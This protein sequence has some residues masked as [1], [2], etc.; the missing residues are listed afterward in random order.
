[1]PVM[2]ETHLSDWGVATA[3]AG[4]ATIANSVGQVTSEALTTAAGTDY[5]LTLTNPLIIANSIVL[6]SPK[7]GTNTTVGLN[8]HEVIPSAGQVIIY[9]RNGHATAALNGTIVISYAVLNFG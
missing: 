4:A 1:M 6:A 9:V 2:L 5:I 8:V 7:P 3:A